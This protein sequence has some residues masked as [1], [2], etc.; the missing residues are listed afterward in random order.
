MT[1]LEPSFS[2]FSFNHY[3]NL[4]PISYPSFD[5]TVDY[6]NYTEGWVSYVSYDDKNCTGSPSHVSNSYYGNCL[7]YQDGNSSWSVMKL[8]DLGE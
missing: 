4:S 7:S 6:N 2:P 1:S 8:I 5:M 3:P